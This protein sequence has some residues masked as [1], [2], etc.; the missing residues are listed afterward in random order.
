MFFHPTFDS[1]IINITNQL[2]L[3]KNCGLNRISVQS[4]VIFAAFV[5]A[6]YLS[7]LCNGCL[8][9]GLFLSCLNPIYQ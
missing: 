9:F 6:P 2:D 4:F 1:K 7:I 8:S 3:Y 5:I